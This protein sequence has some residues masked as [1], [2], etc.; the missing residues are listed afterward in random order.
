M[1]AR[2][3]WVPFCGVVA[4]GIAWAVVRV[5][6]ET[7]DQLSSVIGGV[8]GLL[9]LA[10]SLLA[11]RSPAPALP[12]AA[13]DGG[14]GGR[15]VREAAAHASC[16]APAVPAPVR[17]RDSQ[18]AD[19]ERLAAG[20]NGGLVVV[21]GTGGLGKTTLAAQA[22]RQAEAQGRAVF[23]VRWQDDA[24]RLAHDLT[25]VVKELGLADSR[26]QEAQS[27]QAAL[28]DV[29]W[30]HLAAVRGWMIVI[31]NVDTPRSL[32]PGSELPGAYRGWVRPDGGGLLLVTT[33][34][35]ARETWGPRARLVP[36]E[37][38]ADDPSGRVLRDAAPG[39]GTAQEAA[40]LGQRLGGLPLALETAGRYLANPTSR[41]R[42]FTAYRHALA[43]E[44]GDLVGA[45]H[46][47]A[48]DADVA[49]TVVRHTFD[50]SLT[51]LH[52]DGFTLA[53][54]TL[55]LL[56]L[57]AP[58][59]VPRALLTPAL[60]TDA[61]GR[62]ATAAELDAALA[63]LHQFGLINT[64][65]LL[66]SAGGGGE[67]LAVGQVVLHPVVHDVI[68][69]TAPP[70]TDRTTCY[71]ALDTHLAQ[72]VHDT[73]SA[74]R[75]GWP[76][77]RLLAAHLPPLLHRTSDADFTTRHLLDSLAHTL[78]NA[79]AATEEHLLHQCVLDTETHYL[80]PDHP[81]IL[82]SRHNLANAL[83][84]L[85]RHREAADLHQQN[86]TD[87]ERIQGPD[88]PDTL[89]GRNSLASA[90]DALGR[91]EEAADLH[92][93]SLTDRER[94][95]GPDHPDTLIS[96]HNL[97]IALNAL[98]RHQEAA[99]LHQQSLTDRERVLGPDHP[100]TLASRHNLANALNALGRHREAADLH[101]QSLTDSERILGPD[102]PDTLIS[103]SNFAAVLNA[104]GRH[105]EAAELHQQSLTDRERILGP[106]HPDT[107]IS[108]H[109]LAIALNALGRHQ[110]AAE[111]HQQTLTDCE[112][113]L[114]PDHPHTLT[115]RN[116]LAEI[117][118][119]AARTQRRRWPWQR[120]RP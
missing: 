38:L 98:G 13:G 6:L 22:A 100:D 66:P 110:E 18:L 103:R 45:E 88:H 54:P 49:R 105:R 20:R 73:V 119:A 77:A 3:L 65:D 118:A 40:A 70:G 96:R 35:G 78:H 75:A 33:R 48:A 50:L 92:Q 94:V 113:L 67:A 104:L 9:G 109:N 64:P 71:T 101:Q 23:W 34:D 80:G 19:I 56:A 11:L 1:R 5:G 24:A 89:S 116:N 14:A 87:R 106:D 55:F 63:A 108:R 79:G 57:L 61:T 95:L 15:W 28:V 30:E 107:L 115:I 31:D 59:P 62:T 99:E 83:R 2:L 39:A 58:A 91:Y 52:T 97:A 32:G 37:P 93:Q 72:T 69:L 102:H 21:C 60:L 120:T 74:G 82:A 112:R 12:P 16:R 46:P 7:A 117:R 43:T 29:V 27:G 26:L 10:V 81:D 8:A 44:F 42:T 85:G 53:R 25:R 17:G 47:Q 51:Q 41:Y 76:T 4:G 36:L 90:L 114:G 68:A 86:L 111:L 84:R